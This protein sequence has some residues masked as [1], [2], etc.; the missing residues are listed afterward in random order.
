MLRTVP[1][2]AEVKMKVKIAKYPFNLGK[3]KLLVT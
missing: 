1:H 3:W 2:A